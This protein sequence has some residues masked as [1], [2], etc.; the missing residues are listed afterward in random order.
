MT[1]TTTTA[2]M[3]ASMTTTTRNAR[4]AARRSRPWWP[5][6]FLVAVTAYAGCDAAP[7]APEPA[8]GSRAAG[9]NPDGRILVSKAAPH[10]VARSARAGQ[11]SA[12]DGA[13]AGA[14]DGA[15]GNGANEEGERD[16]AEGDD[17][18]TE[19]QMWEIIEETFARKGELKDGVY[20]LVTPRT[21]LFV[22][23]DGMDV[24]AGAFL[25]SDFRFWRC[26][27]G[28]LLVNGQFVLADYEVNDVVDELQEGRLE[29]VAIAP[30]LLHEHPRLLMVRFQGE[31]RT[32]AFAAALR[33]ALSYTGDERNA[34]QPVDLSP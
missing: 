23:M 27:C 11:P 34:A 18:E 31:G 8:V 14:G 2:S 9:V 10:P 15:D 7:R 13:E 12:P 4:R 16:D 29:V 21:D 25:E 20:R 6:L 24:P 19:A 26:P 33:S 5:P 17:G 32:R 3:T 1:T 30:L 22:T 28:K